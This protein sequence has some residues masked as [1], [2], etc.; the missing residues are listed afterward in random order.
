MKTRF[1]TLLPILM[2][3]A[4][5]LPI[6]GCGGS[7]TVIDRSQRDQAAVYNMQLATDYFRQGNLP[8]AKEKIERALEQDSRNAQAHMVAGLLYQ[9]LGDNDKADSH[10]DRALALEPRNSEI[11]NNYAQYLC[12]R[13]KI[14]RGEKMFL[15]AAKDP[16]Y[17][18]PEAAYMNAGLCARSGGDF[19]DAEKHFRSALEIKQNFPSALLAMADL[20]LHNDRPLQAR[21]FLERYFSAAPTNAAALLLG[22]RIERSLGNQSQADDYARRLRDDYPNSD[23]NRALRG[24]ASQAPQSV[25]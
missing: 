3:L 25:R 1:R 23:E 21:A 10:F 8:L 7:K 4:S 9:R 24:A 18:T 5:M 15:A 20:E 14:D 2:S 13:G 6:G 19:K 12:S 17:K 16:L 11:R 22:V